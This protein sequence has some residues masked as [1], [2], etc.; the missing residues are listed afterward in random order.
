MFQVLA[1]GRG[2]G[3]TLL[4]MHRSAALVALVGAFGCAQPMALD[5]RA[6]SNEAS[7]ELVERARLVAGTDLA[8]EFG[9]L[10][11][12][13]RPTRVLGLPPAPGTNPRPRPP[14]PPEQPLPP[15]RL[16]DNLFYVGSEAVGATIID[17]DDGLI[18]ID[19]LTLDGDVETILLPGMAELGLDPHDIRY[20]IVTHAHGDHHGGVRLL[21]ERYPNFRVIMSE[22]D[23][24]YSLMPYYMVDGGLD[25]ASKPPRREGDIS[26]TGTYDLALGRTKVRIVETPGHT[27]GTSSLFYNVTY[28]AGEAVVMQ[29]GGGSPL[30]SGV[31]LS[32]VERFVQEAKSA[33]PSAQW[34]SHTT[35]A[36][37]ALFAPAYRSG[38]EE[39]P[40]MWDAAVM[41]RYLDIVLLCK[42]AAS[43]SGL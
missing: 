27:P 36:A 43:A 21:R 12:K 16:F 37:L 41:D 30:N 42:K 7:M 23:W 9:E 25:P 14:R 20:V 8:E 22:A 38:P 40:L 39:H 5:D 3:G 1:D 6:Y 29:W 15:T 33:K 4:S 35:A 26:Y 31:Q 28:E 10:C 24:A 13:P 34:S 19:T 17:T 2:R 11:V 32:S 18:L